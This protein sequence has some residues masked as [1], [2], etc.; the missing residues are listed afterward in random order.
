[1]QESIKRIIELNGS[2]NSC[3]DKIKHYNSFIKTMQSGGLHDGDEFKGIEI[4]LLIDNRYTR[5]Y[6]NSSDGYNHY[7]KVKIDT[8]YCD[9]AKEE[10]A[11]ILSGLIIKMQIKIQ[12][13]E[14]ELKTLVK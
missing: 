3:R 11:E 14:E 4:V 12:E 10:I 1:M 5:A 2:L 13:M 9:F 7:P 6:K 8:E